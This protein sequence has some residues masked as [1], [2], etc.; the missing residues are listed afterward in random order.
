M[1]NPL[2]IILFFI[3]FFGHSQIG[4]VSG[5]VS[6]K[7]DNLPLVG[8][9]VVLTTGS[10]PDPIGTATNLDGEF[11]FENLE[12]GAYELTVSY[13]GYETQILKIII[14]ANSNLEK[15]IHLHN[16]S[17]EMDLIVI[18]AGKFEQKL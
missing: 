4:S 6:D 8:V 10:L 15:T 18:S 7:G 13:I 2:L 3:F 11:K 9:N 14:K 12:E 16:Q 1:K 17:T 5:L